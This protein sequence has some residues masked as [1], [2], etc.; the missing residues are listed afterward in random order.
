MLCCGL[1]ALIAAAVAGFWR[2]L[3][4]YPKWMLIGSG[5]MLLALPAAVLAAAAQTR[6]NGQG[7]QSVLMQAMQSICG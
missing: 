2:R 5:A 1:V 3:R 4:G 7:R 6:E